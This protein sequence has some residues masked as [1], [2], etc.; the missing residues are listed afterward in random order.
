MQNSAF[1]GELKNWRNID[2]NIFTM[3]RRETKR[4]AKFI[5]CERF[6]CILQM[7]GLLNGHDGTSQTVHNRL[8]WVLWHA[9]ELNAAAPTD[10]RPNTW[11]SRLVRSVGPV[12]VTAAVKACGQR[13]MRLV[14]HFGSPSAATSGGYYKHIPHR[15]WGKDNRYRSV[16]KQ[17]ELN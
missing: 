8:W 6:H 4:C 2:M 15:K 5:L 16:E 11:G 12:H 17:F 13:G 7:L 10:S 1:V 9:N 14:V 3:H